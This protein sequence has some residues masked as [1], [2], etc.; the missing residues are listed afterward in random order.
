MDCFNVPSMLR[1]FDRIKRPGGRL[2]R[3]GSASALRDRLAAL[4]CP[5]LRLAGGIGLL[6]LALAGR[7]EPGGAGRHVAA[8]GRKH[9]FTV[10]D[11]IQMVRFNDPY[12]R[13]Q[14]SQAKR[15]PN[16]KYFAVVT[17]RGIIQSNKI[18][19]TLWLFPAEK[20]K[21]FLDAGNEAHG[22][23]P[24][25]LTRVEAVPRVPHNEP[26]ES[27][28]T[29]VRWSPDSRT[30][31]FLA[32]NS[33]AERRLCRVDPV[34]GS[35]RAL[36]PRGYD[37]N[38]FA[39]GGGGIVYTAARSGESLNVG[40]PINS[41]A[42]AVTGE[43]ISSLLF[44][45]KQDYL[46]YEELWA[47][48]R[49]K[50]VRI[51]NPQADP[52]LV[53]L[54]HHP[55]VLSLSPDG[56]RVVVLVPVGETPTLWESYQPVF[57]YL[58]IDA[59]NRDA[60]AQTNVLR[61]TEYVV[62]D[63]LA[64]TVTRLANAPNAWA[65]G[66]GDANLA[67]WSRD[68]KT[69]L[70]SN[71]FLPQDGVGEVERS[72]RARPCIAAVV[73]IASKGI[74]CLAFGAGDRRSGLLDASFGPTDS[75]VVLRFSN[76]TSEPIERRYQYENGVWKLTGLSRDPRGPGPPSDDSNKL[77]LEV[78]QDLN[79]PPSLWAVDSRTARRKKLWD[80]NPELSN[81]S[82]GAVSVFRWKDETGYE[83]VGGLIKP[84]DYRPGT[85]YPLVIQT[86]G[87]DENEFM[88]DGQFTTAFAASPLAS[89]G[90]VVLQVRSRED[91]YVTADEALEQVRGFKAAID[92]LASDGL[93]DGQRVGIVGF[94][95]TSYYV[96]SALIE[97][98]KYFAAATLVDGVDLSYLQYVL[99]SVG[100]AGDEAEQIYGSK[101]F[102]EGL[103]NWMERAPGFH[104]DQ[105]QTPVRIEA[106]E[107]SGLL[108]EWEIYASL[109]KQGKP[110][111]LIYIPDGQHILQ[112]PLERLASQQGNV[113]WFRFWL[114]GEE[115]PDPGKAQQY[116]R[117][118]ELRSKALVR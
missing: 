17:S 25:L 59:K 86:H 77:S 19:S 98:P 113:D 88:T 90:M 44:P 30:L 54:N 10:R 63:L 55:R 109:W 111:D 31:L 116:L 61:L 45:N 1:K 36:T 4:R 18:E 46:R 71:T 102:G 89:A 107:P 62:V 42:R 39:V 26:Y 103:A 112:K 15:S 101:P 22:P 11:S 85:R 48:R 65:L 34:S 5:Y 53:L 13:H 49:G 3:R 73:T 35:V 94:S 108:E 64:G 7:L 32:Q 93:I 83:W 38:Q 81:V 72:D 29:E 100:G 87:F 51:S 24:Q 33:N 37:V 95:R 40:S 99:L 43:S 57:S 78:K 66:Y 47:I 68:G 60:T 70:V 2:K 117:W 92:R 27:V 75:E 41:N 21:R 14:G 12:T 74:E 67:K 82:M 96:E 50:S 91:H 76:S 104:L 97:K 105:I 16:R 114:K 9:T 80:P 84:P 56:R 69:V 58:R 79:T 118:R 20:V 110:V 8:D 115:D 52:Q 106:L 28:I 6:V 23:G